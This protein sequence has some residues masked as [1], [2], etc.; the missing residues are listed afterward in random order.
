MKKRDF[1]L[2]I[3]LAGSMLVGGCAREPEQPAGT[4]SAAQLLESPVYEIEVSIYGKVS[5]LGEL[6]CPCFVLASGGES[7]EVWY[8]L[9]VEED[10]TERPAVSVEGIDNGDWVIVTGELR[11]SDGLLPSKTFWAAGIEKIE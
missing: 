7:V 2:S 4:L 1:L 5:A 11:S 6:L 3:L 9:M 10:G 8:G